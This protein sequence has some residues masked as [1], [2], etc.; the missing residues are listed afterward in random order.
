MPTV[1]CYWS[2]HHHAA[3]KGCLVRNCLAILEQFPNFLID[4]VQIELTSA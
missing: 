2:F 1:L 4:E 3:C